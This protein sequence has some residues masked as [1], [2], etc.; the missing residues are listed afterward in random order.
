MSELLLEWD[1]REDCI[2]SVLG[3]VA[4]AG[5]DRFQKDWMILIR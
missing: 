2:G 1:Q 5:F 3:F 4:E